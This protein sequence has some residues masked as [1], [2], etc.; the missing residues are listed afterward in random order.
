MRMKKKEC[1]WR[2]ERF[3][4]VQSCC[5]KSSHS[6]HIHVHTFFSFVQLGVK[7]KTSGKGRFNLFIWIRFWGS[8][9]QK[10]LLKGECRSFTRCAPK[11]GLE[12]EILKSAVRPKLTWQNTGKKYSIFFSFFFLICCKISYVFCFFKKLKGAYSS[13]SFVVCL[14]IINNLCTFQPSFFVWHLFSCNYE[15]LLAH[16]GFSLP[17]STDWS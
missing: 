8:I 15:K 1:R 10:N 4:K 9:T 14:R 16:K 13:D 6:P 11:S 12:L 3:W 17:G 7:S 5:R 2:K